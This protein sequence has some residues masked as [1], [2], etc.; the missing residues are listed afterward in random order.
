MPVNFAANDYLPQRK[1]VR[2]KNGRNLS[3]SINIDLLAEKVKLPFAS[4]IDPDFVKQKRRKAI[5]N[6]SIDREIQ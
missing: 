3:Q 1:V 2:K 4:A 6:N 5:I